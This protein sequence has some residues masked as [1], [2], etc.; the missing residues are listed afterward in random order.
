MTLR[1]ECARVWRPKDC[2]TCLRHPTSQPCPITRIS[3]L[4]P[5]LPAGLDRLGGHCPHFFLPSWYIHFDCRTLR[6][7]A[8]FAGPTQFEIGS[9]WR[10][11]LRKSLPRS[12]AVGAKCFIAAA[13]RSDDP[14]SLGEPSA[15]PGR[16]RAGPAQKLRSAL[17]R[18]L[19]PHELFN[20]TRSPKLHCGPPMPSGWSPIRTMPKSNDRHQFQ[21]RSKKHHHILRRLV[22]IVVRRENH[23]FS[24][25]PILLL[26]TSSGNEGQTLSEG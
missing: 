19:F 22:C 26:P 14:S 7:R 21:A 2:G 6:R 12:V 17:L 3:N 18:R 15:Q 16:S 13:C 23:A 11:D 4:G 8:S 9:T 20:R 24:S 5:P 10:T 25:I 1:T